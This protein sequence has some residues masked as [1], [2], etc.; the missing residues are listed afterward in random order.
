MDV[1]NKIIKISQNENP[2]GPSPK[3]IEALKIHASEAHLY[4]E[5][6]AESLREIIAERQGMRT[7]EVLVT[8]GLIEALDILIRNFI[9]GNEEVLVSSCSFVA[10][11]MLANVFGRQMRFAETSDGKL[12]ADSFIN[13]INTQTKLILIDNPNNPS[14]TYLSE[15]E[16]VSILNKVPEDCLLVLDEAYVEYVDAKD[17]PDSLKLL[18]HHTNLLVLRSFSKIHGLA[19]LRIGYCIGNEDVIERMLHFQAPFTVNRLACSAA[20]SALDDHA[21]VDQSSK[22][23]AVERERLWNAMYKAGYDVLPSQANF[24]LL[25]FDTVVERDAC[26]AFLADNQIHARKT[27]LFGADR[28]LRIS[29]AIPV[30]NTFVIDILTQFKSNNS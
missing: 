30:D 19:G 15:D 16:I 26:Y 1:M 22:A 24:L 11:R 13:A 25:Q 12:N 28:G 4:P 21:H 29:C 7:E 8:A 10:Y 17:Y 18:K 3:A 27:D 14:G 20:K 23:N 9:K 5:P 2:F 6:H